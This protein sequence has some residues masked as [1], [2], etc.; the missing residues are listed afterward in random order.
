MIDILQFYPWSHL[1]LDLHFFFFGT[2][3][4]WTWLQPCHQPNLTSLFKH[5]CE[6][7]EDSMKA[8]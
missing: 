8:D 1:D 4:R 5:E 2:Q 3:N 6:E 7:N